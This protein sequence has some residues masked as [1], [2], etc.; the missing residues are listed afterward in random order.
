MAATYDEIRDDIL[1]ALRRSEIALNYDIQGKTDAQLTAMAKDMPDSL[2][3]E[4]LLFAAT[5]TN[6]MNEQL[7]IYKEV[8]RIHPNDYR[9]ANNVGYIYMMQNKLADAEAQFQK[10]NSIQDNPVST[11]NLGVVARLKGDRKR[12]P[13]STTRPWPPVPR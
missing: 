3:V 4:E 10:A 12:P 11:N 1:P 7:R 9:G 8:E 13:S 2:N 6:D 5:L